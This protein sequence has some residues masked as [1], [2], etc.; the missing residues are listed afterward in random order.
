MGVYV[1]HAFLDGIGKLLND[2]RVLFNVTLPGTVSSV[3]YISGFCSKRSHHIPASLALQSGCK[4]LK[5]HGVVRIIAGKCSCGQPEVYALVNG[6]V[7]FGV[8]AVL[9]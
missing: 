6:K 8:H 3:R 9:L 1:V 2:F 5:F 4:R 7:C